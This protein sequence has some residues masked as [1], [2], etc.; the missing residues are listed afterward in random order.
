M[1]ANTWS[2]LLAIVGTLASIAGVVFGWLAWVQA[3][4]AKDAAREAANAV[5]TRNLAHSFSNWA[6]DAR[7]LL[8]SVRESHFESAQHAA[9]NLL[10]ALSHNKGWQAGLQRRDSAVEKVVRTLSLV[11]TYLSDESVFFD[12][13]TDLAEDCQAIYTRLNELAGSIDAQAEK[14]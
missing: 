14:P 4:A 6:V 8:R 10:G 2:W 5:R 3:A 13:Q 1:T 9:I 11:N 7:E 12:K